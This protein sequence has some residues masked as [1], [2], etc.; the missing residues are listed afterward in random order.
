[1]KK[2]NGFTLI[3]LLAVI[4]I[5]G[6]LMII[7]VPA[8][9]KYIIESKDSSYI[10]TAK[11]LI[12]GA[13]KKV[14]TKELGRLDKKTTYY[15]PSS[16]I[17]TDNSARSPY[18]DFTAAYIGIIYGE[19]DYKYF[20]I[21]TDEAGHG[22]KKM[23]PLEELDEDD[24]EIGVSSEDIENIVE[25]KGIGKRKNIKVLN[26]D[27]DNNQW[28]LI[29]LTNTRNNYLEDGKDSTIVC[30]PA[31]T[32]HTVECTGANS[33]CTAAGYTGENNI[34]TYGTIPIGTPNPGDAYDCKVNVDGDYTERFYYL[35]SE[36]N[37]STLI[38]Y[39]SMNNG[40]AYAYDTVKENWHGPRNAYLY[41]PDISDWNNPG[42]IAPGT[43][44]IVTQN[45]SLSTSGGT[46]ENFAYT[47]KAARLLTTQ[48]IVNAC[49]GMSSVGSY[50]KGE[51]DPCNYLLENVTVYESGT[52]SVY[53][54]WT[55]TP[56]T[57]SKTYI[58]RVAG[59]DRNVHLSHA[60]SGSDRAVRPVITILT[61]NISS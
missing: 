26:C 34:I 6:V 7:A 50:K 51:L 46:I 11:S 61:S 25:N 39:K 15:I 58:W 35:G 59:T 17:K 48:E 55:E 42:L 53:G 12:E 16:C 3:E 44:Q 27:N 18:G 14:I 2:K 13:R 5:L 20:W 57:N 52:G 21:S 32:L 28:E 36:G 29:E 22:V 45:G 49:S 4:I 47:G 56:Q 30:Y 54:Y 38:Y 37:Q 31:T 43:R 33:G 1:M 8:V 9:T 19:S 41:L 40:T 60:N 24:I 10:Y 23:T